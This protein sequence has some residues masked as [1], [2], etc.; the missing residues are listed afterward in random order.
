VNLTPDTNVLV[1]LVVDDDAEQGLMAVEMLERASQI[2]I[3][4]HALCEM[5]WVLRGRYG[6]G[7]AEIAVAIRGLIGA[8]NV[9]ANRPAIEAGLSLLEAGGD[10]ADGV[11]AFEG[12]WLGGGTFASFDKSAVKLLEGQGNAALLIS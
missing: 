9:V 6:M 5:V 10:F 1:R 4:V 11:I 3:S 7:R 8:G 2:A 12:R